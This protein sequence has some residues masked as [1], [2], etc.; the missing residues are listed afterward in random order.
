MMIGRRY[1]LMRRLL[2][3]FAV[4]SL[5][6]VAPVSTG[7][8]ADVSEELAITRQV[9]DLLV[10]NLSAPPDTAVLLTN[11]YAEAQRA[12]GGQGALPAL[13]GDVAAQW[14]VFE[15]SVRD[16]AA[17]SDANLALGDLRSRL[18][19]SMV[20]TVSDG[21][22]F[23]LT[24]QESDARKAVNVGDTSI[25]NYGYNVVSYNNG[26]YIAMLAP[27]GSMEAAG[28]RVGDQL[29]AIDDQT[30]TRA[31]YSGLIAK[32]EEGSIH[33]FTVLHRNET[34]PVRLTVTITRYV[35][36]PLVF[37]VIDGHVGYIQVFTFSYRSLV[38]KLDEALA[39]LHAQ[40]V[41]S[42]ILD[43]RDNPGGMDTLAQRFLGRF[44]P[45][46][47]IVGTDEGRIYA[48][49]SPQSSLKAQKIA[50]GDGHDPDTLPIA[51]LVN[52]RST[53]W[54]EMAPLALHEF[55]DVPLIGTKT[56]GLLGND[57]IYPLRDGTSISV[58]VGIYTSAQGQALN[59]V[60]ITPDVA[61]T[62]PTAEEIINGH[63]APLD[64][65]IMSVNAK[66][67]TSTFGPL[68]AA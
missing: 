47:T 61:V 53:L 64:A 9:Y 52:S 37:R 35:R 11:A 16:L 23:Y 10:A 27:G 50:Q 3:L 22:T 49:Q 5:L 15:S 34:E 41:D 8:A 33:T 6:V 60:G 48:R 51:A 28:G 24:K 25:A 31:N 44:L 38:D 36:Q 56:R 14:D 40:G 42:L 39:A 13:D 2:L 29:L 58:T 21:H 32:Q 46:G 57:V 30:V 65:A 4:A 68:L 62:N 19:R 26:D 1:W 7:A 43:L 54:G 66:V 63:D 12:L 67:Y 55:R 20:R 59:K 18:I 17:S 45:T